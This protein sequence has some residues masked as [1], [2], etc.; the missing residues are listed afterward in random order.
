[1]W[2]NDRIEL[3]RAEIRGVMARYDDAFTEVRRSL[4]RLGALE[5]RAERE[6]AQEALLEAAAEMHDTAAVLEDAAR[7]IVLYLTTEKGV[8]GNQAAKALGLNSTTVTRWIKRARGD[9]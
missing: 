2:E 6:T 8:K 3:R 7:E 4:E 5:D 1:M 9:D